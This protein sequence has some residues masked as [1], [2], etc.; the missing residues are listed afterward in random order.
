MTARGHA[1]QGVTTLIIFAGLP[2]T[3]KTTIARELARALGAV[4][5]RID[6]IEQAMRDSRGRDEPLDDTG[7]RVAYAVAEE[8]LSLGRCVVADSVNPLKLTRE[9]WLEVAA[10]THVCACEVEVMCSDAEEHRRRAQTRTADIKGLRL[11]SWDEIVSR[12]YHAW[13]REHLVVDTAYRTVDECVGIIRAAI[14][15]RMCMV[16]KR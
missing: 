6:S 11:P 10:R 15:K 16:D 1:G 14:E 8:N 3:G 13:N 12:E 5:V 2:A 7:Y 4:Y 9:A